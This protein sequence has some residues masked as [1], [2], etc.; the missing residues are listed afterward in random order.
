MVDSNT[1]MWRLKLKEKEMGTKYIDEASGMPLRPL[2]ETAPQISEPIRDLLIRGKHRDPTA[3][4]RYRDIGANRNDL[5][6]SCRLNMSQKEA[7][8]LSESNFISIIQGQ[9]SDIVIYDIVRS[10]QY[11]TIGFLENFK[12][13]NVAIS[14]ARCLLIVVGNATMFPSLEAGKCFIV[15]KDQI[16]TEGRRHWRKLLEW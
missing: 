14:R 1:A 13:L 10:N 16:N 7:V 4:C 3:T 11:L 6:D 15:N 2:N 8:R 5:F 12:R 9:E